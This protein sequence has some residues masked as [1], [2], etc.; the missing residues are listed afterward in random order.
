M[1]RALQRQE[2][3]AKEPWGAG[4]VL[5]PGEGKDGATG[6]HLSSVSF[7]LGLSPGRC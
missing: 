5:V 3:G 6:S 2:L 1:R 4:A 7:R